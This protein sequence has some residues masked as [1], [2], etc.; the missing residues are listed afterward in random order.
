MWSDHSKQLP[1]QVIRIRLNIEKYRHFFVADIFSNATMN[2]STRTFTSR[3]KMD[4]KCANQHWNWIREAYYFGTHPADWVHG[5]VFWA[6]GMIWTRGFRRLCA[7]CE[8]KK[9]K[10]VFK[11][12]Q[13]T[14]PWMAFAW[15]IFGIFLDFFKG[16]LWG[17][18]FTGNI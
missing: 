13:G 4:S 6:W 5:F 8:E 3:F 15:K 18:P 11:F 12:C 10:I 17:K 2:T 7:Y 1:D 16:G 14:C 9:R